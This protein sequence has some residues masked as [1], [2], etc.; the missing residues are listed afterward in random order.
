M[1]K[2]KLTR[3]EKRASKQAHAALVA[4][5]QILDHTPEDMKREQR[6]DESLKPLWKE[7]QY[8]GLKFKEENGL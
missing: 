4:L 1:S 3:S 5:P 8:R 2:T 6:E 7:A